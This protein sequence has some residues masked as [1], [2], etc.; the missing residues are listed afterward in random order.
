MVIN[1]HYTDYHYKNMLH[2]TSFTTST[3]TYGIYKFG[4]PSKQFVGFTINAHTDWLDLIY[5]IWRLEDDYQL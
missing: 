5:R 1:C 3:T 2:S 4:V